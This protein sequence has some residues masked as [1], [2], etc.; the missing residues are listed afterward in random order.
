MSSLLRGLRVQARVVGALA[1]RETRTRFGGHA[2][3]YVWALA[4]PVFW[5][6]TFYGLYVLLNRRVPERLDV[7]AFLATGMIGYELVMKTQ[8]RVS[9]SISGNKALLFYPQVQ[10]LDLV[11]ARVALELATY[12]VILV[13][14]LGGNALFRGELEIASILVLTF[15][16][17]LA[18]LLGGSLGLV[19]AA[20]QLVFPTVERMKGPL[21]RPLFWISGLFFTAHVLPIR[22]REIFLWNPIFHCLEIV[23]AGW[24]PGY[25]GEHASPGY[26]MAWI[27]VL[28]F[29][30]LTLER[31]LRH[32]IEV[33]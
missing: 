27:L 9:A 32:R 3:G 26:V 24:F 20:A 7:F 17:L 15:G 8:D 1:L 25:R 19:L 23:R 12:V 30:G 18:T 33:T 5:I 29:I 28:A 13:I 6:F 10:P 14:L 4:E 22:M 11:I 21:M 16:L 2:L 31:S